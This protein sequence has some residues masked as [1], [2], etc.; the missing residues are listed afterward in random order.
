[1]GAL[2]RS[3]SGEPCATPWTLGLLPFAGAYAIASG[4]ARRSAER[5]RARG[6]LFVVAVGNLT[7][8]GTGKSSVARWLAREAAGAGGRSALVLRGHGADESREG[9]SAVPDFAG[10]PLAGA[11]KRYGDEALAHRAALPN[12]VAVIVDR[13]RARAASAAKQGYGASVAVLDD[14]W[15]QGRLAWD[16][17]WVTLDPHRP[18]GNGWPLPAGPLRRPAG[19]LAAATVIAYLLESEE[20]TVPGSTGSLVARLAPRAAVVRFRRALRGLSAIGDP[21][22][23]PWG[24]DRGE[25]GL[26]TAIGAP[27]RVERFARAAG[28]PV[29]AHEAFPDHA[30][31]S[32]EQLRVALERLRR[33]GASVALVTEKDE[34]RWTFPDSPPLPVMVLRAD[35]VPLDPVEP[36][37][38]RLRG[39]GAGVC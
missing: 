5:T 6:G 17:L 24:P 38:R 30:A 1:M 23:S 13:D 11:V 26:V 18:L 7:V 21:R 14:G 8:G 33:R 28:I 29:V 12:S 37:L 27:A 39:T 35:V 22:C 3:W 25:A 31:A 15:E 9:P 36:V 2:E 20:E 10:Y 34:H 16:E 19:T 32:P 4:M